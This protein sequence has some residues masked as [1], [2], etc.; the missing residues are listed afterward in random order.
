MSDA[1]EELLKQFDNTLIDDYKD[2]VDSH[3]D[4]I[5]PDCDELWFSLT[6]G[7]ALGRG[8]DPRTA[9]SF[10]EYIWH[11]TDLG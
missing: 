7:W 8:L 4:E 9:R 10:A 5:D 1:A 2:N 6:L 11:H 3:C